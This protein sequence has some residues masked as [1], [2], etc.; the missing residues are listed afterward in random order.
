M[1]KLL[2]IAFC[3][4]M[5]MALA[6]G[7]FAATDDPH[8]GHEL[9][10]V[11]GKEATCTEKGLSDGTFCTDCGMFVVNQKTIP[12]KG[13]NFENHV[14]TEC[15]ESHNIVEAP[16]KEPTCT[17]RGLTEGTFCM[18][19]M[20]FVESQK[21]IP[22]TGHNFVDGDCTVCGVSEHEG[23][24][25][26][27]A[28][29]REP[30]CTERGLTEGTFCMDCM[31]FVE[32]QKDIPATGHNFENHVC[33]ECGESHNI[34]EVPGKEATCTEKGLTDGTF[35]MDCGKFVVN[36]KDIPV[37]DH[38][39]AD[40]TCTM[41]GEADPDCKHESTR[42]E[43]FEA[44][45][46]KEGTSTVI[47]NDCGAEVSTE[48]LPTNDNHA[49]HNGICLLCGAEEV[50]PCE[51]EYEVVREDKATCLE[52]GYVWEKCT[53]CGMENNYE[54]VSAGEHNYE[55][56]KC[57]ACGE[58]DPNCKHEHT[59]LEIFEA[60]CSKEGSS[61]VVCKDCGFVISTETLPTNDNHAFH[62]GTCLLCGAEEIL[63]CEHEYE[64]VRELKA[65]C[66][67]N[68]YVWEKCTKCGW[69]HNYEVEGLG[70]HN[71]ETG[72]C[73][74]CGEPDPDCK[75]EST[76][77]DIVEANCSKEGI[78]VVICKHCGVEVSSEILPVNDNHAFVNHI[79]LLCG[80]EEVLPCEHEYEVVRELKATCLENGYVWEKC[81]KCG[82]E[83]NYEV[84]GLG[85]HNYET[86]K[87]T[88]CGE[89]DPNCKHEHTNLDII[90]ANCSKEGTSSV[91]CS[92]CGFV[93][94]TET[95][96]INENHAFHN[97]T[98][99]LCGAAEPTEPEVEPTE[100][101]VEPTEPEV[102]PTEPE[103]EPTEPE[104]EPTEPE[105]EPTEPEAGSNS[106]SVPFAG[107]D[108]FLVVAIVVLS[109]TGLIIL[110]SKKRIF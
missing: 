104:V 46:S 52:N 90:E 80:E 30:T 17:E 78:C 73:D 103:V 106:E 1:K 63:P 7:T 99:L 77:L 5:V 31:I 35:C 75:H 107:D 94:S 98:C 87:C 53:K 41:C 20:I 82:W 13:H 100:P 4:V 50:L 49:F 43:V 108:S 48:T 69:E 101:E 89:A 45:C 60:N 38:N 88:V 97:G 22:A 29:S 9:V 32:S 14:C 54:V 28:P 34:V 62:E 12:A 21:D 16:S 65:T 18:D 15:G 27:T 66:L 2:S 74:V 23:H 71:Y 58:A 42:V 95:L 81:T 59:S 44:N 84:E 86:G 57:T 56:G 55:A 67:E 79:C 11:P 64:V 68:G 105:V 92:D 24:E 51:H 6:I 25:L 85:E 8:E 61:S 91:V 37:K 72:K 33:T 76:R 110:V 36:Q 19:C 83:H 39:Y 70:E 47:C 3:L 96:P 10:E 102:E 26:A 109:M 93:I 40:G